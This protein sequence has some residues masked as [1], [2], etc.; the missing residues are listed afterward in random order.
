MVVSDNGT[1]FT[2]EEYGTFMA[3]NGILHVKTAPGYPSCNGHVLRSV[4]IFRDR[5]NKLEGLKG[6][7]HTKLRRFLLAY[8]STPQPKMGFKP[9]ELLFN[10]CQCT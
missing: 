4:H 10:R 3:K 6:T 2:S 5:I 1:G 9:G 8:R 7:V